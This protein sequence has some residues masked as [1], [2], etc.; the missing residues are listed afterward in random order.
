MALK[1]KYTKAEK[2]KIL[3][4]IDEEYECLKQAAALI[5]ACPHVVPSGVGIAEYFE[6]L[7]KNALS[8]QKYL[9]KRAIEGAESSE[10]IE[11]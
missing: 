5:A 3:E 8:L 1:D 9:Y 4:I 6:E 10:W 2:A 7:K 11:Y